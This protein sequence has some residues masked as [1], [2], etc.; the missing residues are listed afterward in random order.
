MCVSDHKN[1][2]QF[3]GHDERGFI[4]INGTLFVHEVNGNL[5]RVAEDETLAEHMDVYNFSCE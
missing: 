1:Y 2:S 4:R 3:T 5:V